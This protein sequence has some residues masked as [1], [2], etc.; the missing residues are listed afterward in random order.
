MNESARKD[1]LSLPL[2]DFLRDLA[3]V[4]PTPGGGSTAAL[5]GALGASLGHMVAGFALK[6]AEK[7]GTD[8]QPILH[9]M[10]RLDRAAKLLG[11][12]I[13]EDIAAYDLYRQTSK[14]DPNAPG[15]V[16]Q[17]KLATMAALAIPSQILGVSAAC[18]RDMVD[19]TPLSSKYLWTD[20]AAAAQMSAAAAEAAA[21][22]V[23]ANL[24][25]PD[26]TAE[27]RQQMSEEVQHQRES[28][29]RACEQVTDYV[30]AR[31]IEGK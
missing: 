28:A 7:Q 29:T 27:E 20:L 9:I 22:T 16:E 1:Y 19:L 8:T 10:E 23:F 15:T 26:L 3:N 17:K 6:R 25:S 21:W 18:L 13:A 31:V 5:T 24:N 14:L 12:L 30:Q 4:S 2:N 11:G